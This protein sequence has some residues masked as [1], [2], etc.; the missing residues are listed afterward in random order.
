MKMIHD[1]FHV[2]VLYILKHISTVLSLCVFL[3]IFVK[4]QSQLY[5]SNFDSQFFLPLSSYYNM[6]GTGLSIIGLFTAL[7]DSGYIL[8]LVLLL[9]VIHDKCKMMFEYLESSDVYVSGDDF[10]IYGLFVIDCLIVIDTGSLDEN[11]CKETCM[12]IDQGTCIYSLG[13]ISNSICII[14]CTKMQVGCI[15][16][17]SLSVCVINVCYHIKHTHILIRIEVHNHS[18]IYIQK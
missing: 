8:N 15:L 13:T 16:R 12:E 1:C 14:I 11:K 5:M 18:Y 3:C 7:Q 2:R 10:V 4:Q 9:I 17:T 6:N